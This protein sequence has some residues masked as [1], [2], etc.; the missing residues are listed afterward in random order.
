MFT[1]SHPRVVLHFRIFNSLQRNLHGLQ[2][3][4]ALFTR[5]INVTVFFCTIYNGFNAVIKMIKGATHKHDDID[6]Y[7]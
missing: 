3:N 2:L 6:R 7:V 4:E 5:T 1:T